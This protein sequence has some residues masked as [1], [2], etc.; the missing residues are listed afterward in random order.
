MPFSLMGCHTVGVDIAAGRIKE[1]N[2]FF[3]EAGAKGT[4]IANDI[5][6]EK[7]L[8]HN[9]DIVIC[10]DVIEHIAD[11][12][13]FLSGLGNYLK[14]NGVIFMAFPAWQMP[15]GGHQQIC[16]SKVLSHLPFIHLLPTVIYRF[17]LKAFREDNDCVNELLSIKQTRVTIEQFENLLM[18]TDLRVEDRQLWFINPHY[19]VK[20]GL[21]PRKL[22]PLISAIPYLRNFFCTS[23]FYIVVNDRNN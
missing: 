1:A 22:H 19:E 23:C 18:S 10:H 3:N 15:F 2:S 16:R 12:K 17:L 13:L 7:G 6:K 9:F 11:K 20:F 5:F 21:T 14:P 4:F 8:E